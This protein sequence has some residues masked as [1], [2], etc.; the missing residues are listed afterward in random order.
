M[1]KYCKNFGPGNMY[2]GL[3]QKYV[4]RKADTGECVKNCFVLR[5][6]KD[7]AAVAA[8]RAYAGATDNKMLA[9]DIINWIG[10]EQH[11]PLTLDEL[12]EMGGE[13][14]YIHSDIFQDDCGWRVIKRA[15]VLRVY[16]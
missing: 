4:V 14:V 2:E 11:T 5:P 1:S 10:A 15:D 3:K 6:D 16:F 12:R 9:A 8:L 7:V 13:P